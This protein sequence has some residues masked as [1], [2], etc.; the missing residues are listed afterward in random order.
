MV[1]SL[2]IFSCR[3]LLVWTLDDETC[4]HYRTLSS[5]SLTTPRIIGWTWFPA[6]SPPPSSLRSFCLL[7]KTCTFRKPTKHILLSCLNTEVPKERPSLP[8]LS[9]KHTGPTW[10]LWNRGSWNMF[11]WALREVVLTLIEFKPWWKWPK[12]VL[13]IIK[14]AQSENK[15]L[16]LC[17]PNQLNAK[18]YIQDVLWRILLWDVLM[19]CVTIVKPYCV[20]E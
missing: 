11:S 6:K 7:P 18:L 12:F 16:L 4:H 17:Q 9:G 20:N 8:Y 5:I 13:G 10:C 19:L 3:L 1:S 2:S 15:T 14:K